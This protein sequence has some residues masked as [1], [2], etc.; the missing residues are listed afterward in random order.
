VKPGAYVLLTVKDT[1]S[2]MDAATQAQ[3]FE[4]FSRLR[5]RDREPV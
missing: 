5:A 4:P 3:A 1:G 2:G